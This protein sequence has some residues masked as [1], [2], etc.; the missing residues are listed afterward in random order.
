MLHTSSKSHSSLVL[1]HHLSY[2][3]LPNALIPFPTPVAAIY[4]GKDNRLSLRQEV[5]IS[6]QCQFDLR[7]FPFDEQQCA[8]TFQMGEME[9]LLVK[10]KRGEEGVVYKGPKQL[11]EYKVRETWIA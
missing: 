3:A 7:R 2:T 10:L 8:L 4:R 1:P 6:H 5:T 9:S 11:P